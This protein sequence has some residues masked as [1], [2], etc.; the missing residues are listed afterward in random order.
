MENGIEKS[1]EPLGSG[2]DFASISSPQITEENSVNNSVS[3]SLPRFVYAKQNSTIEPTKHVK[4]A[5]RLGIEMFLPNICYHFLRDECIENN[6]CLYSH[7]LL[8]VDKVRDKLYESNAEDVAK[9]FLVI[10]S[11]CPKLLEYYFDTFVEFLATHWQRDDLIRA[12]YICENVRDERQMCRFFRR[13][14]IGFMESG[15]SYSSTIETI[16][17][18]L[19]DPKKAVVDILLDT[20]IVGGV[21][22]DDITSIFQ[23]LNERQYAFNVHSLNRLM[24]LCVWSND[25]NFAKVVI[26]VIKKD[27]RLSRQGLDGNVFKRI[28]D[29]YVN[30]IAQTK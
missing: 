20:N 21:T 15:M 24:Q 30:L 25:K 27:R 6:D 18:K 4:S 9:I 26:K 11:R 8:S 23:S 16:F 3:V 13:L 12:I 2:Y 29:M 10:I 5:K 17:L 28:M 1:A 22:C 19:K 7:E 14:I